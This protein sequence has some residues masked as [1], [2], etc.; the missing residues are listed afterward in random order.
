M[1][2]VNQIRDTASAALKSAESGANLAKNTLEDVVQNHP[3]LAIATVASLGLLLG[4][5]ISRK[6]RPPLRMEKLQRMAGT[7]FRSRDLERTIKRLE[8]TVNRGVPRAYDTVRDGVSGLPEMIASLAH[9][10]QNKVASTLSDV[11]QSM[12]NVSDIKKA[13][14]NSAQK[15]TG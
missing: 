5:T 10:W 1:T 11:K 9:V 15:W 3:L 7:D 13:A 4:V 14:V 2:D 8:K 6:S 12:P